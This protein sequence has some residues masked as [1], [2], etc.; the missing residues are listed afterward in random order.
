M[1]KV[2]G[3]N[4]GDG[5]W[6]MH[7]NRAVSAIVTKIRYSKFV[8]SI[9]YKTIVESEL[10]SVSVDDKQLYDSFRK[11]QLFPTKTDLIKSL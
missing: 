4:V 2:F 9:D 5:V 10:Y 7:G 11:E 1:K 3:I 6:L 8:S